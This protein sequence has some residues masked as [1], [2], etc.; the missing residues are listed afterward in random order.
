MRTEF[1]PALADAP[2]RN[3]VEYAHSYKAAEWRS[4]LE[5]WGS[6]LLAEHL[7]TRVYNNLLVLSELWALATDREVSPAQIAKIRTL[8]ERFVTEYEQIYYNNIDS[9]MPACTLQVHSLLHL[10]SW[11]QDLGS[12]RYWWQFP[13]ER[14]CGL[15]K[16]LA[17]SKSRLDEIMANTVLQEEQLH[18]LDLFDKRRSSYGLHGDHLPQLKG[19][20]PQM[21]WSAWDIK[22]LSRVLYPFVDPVLNEEAQLR[23]FAASA[24]LFK[25]CYI[26]NKDRPYGSVKSQLNLEQ[27][28][29]NSR[30][31]YRSRAGNLDYAV[32]L[33]Y[34]HIPDCGYYADIEKLRDV[35]V[36]QYKRCV[37]TTADPN[38]GGGKDFV[39]IEA[40]VCQVGVMTMEADSGRNVY[41]IV[42]PITHLLA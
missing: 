38:G 32:V 19:E 42:G 2:P 20:L 10:S 6:P 26:D 3:I 28:R 35:K 14:L 11:I 33:H 30:I 15:T 9:H 16:Q 1:P 5:S 13:F 8:S 25:R 31:C 34:L 23:R 7:S 36:G 22:R 37:V 27:R 12:A 41:Y 18:L 39:S 21:R 40:I 29:N 17:T 4:F 24:L